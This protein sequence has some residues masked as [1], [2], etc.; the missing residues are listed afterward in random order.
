ME[1]DTKDL[2][3]LDSNRT[4]DYSHVSQQIEDEIKR[5]E[6]T[7]AHLESKTTQVANEDH[8]AYRRMR[9]SLRKYLNVLYQARRFLSRHAPLVVIEQCLTRLISLQAVFK[10]YAAVF[11][12]TPLCMSS[13]LMV[14]SKKQDKECTGNFD[15]HCCL[16]DKGKSLY[17]SLN[18]IVPPSTLNAYPVFLPPKKWPPKGDDDRD[19][20]KVIIVHCSSITSDSC[21][22]VVM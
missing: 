8:I 7:L 6:Q 4:S 21:K 22:Y 10:K 19:K 18:L 15:S 3:E 12:N 9:S 14:E 20:L 11:R 17:D 13:A 5:V 16:K 1:E 2:P